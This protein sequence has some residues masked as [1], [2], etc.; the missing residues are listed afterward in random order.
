[1]SSD[2]PLTV[3]EA[4]ARLKLNPEVIRRMLRDGRLRG[5]QPFSKRAGWRI[6]V[7]EIERVERGVA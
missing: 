4:A 3:A 6:P 1:M 2:P 5:S 7:A